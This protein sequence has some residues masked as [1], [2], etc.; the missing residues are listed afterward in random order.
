MNEKPVDNAIERRVVAGEVRA[1]KAESGPT[2]LAGYAAL[3][4]RETVIEGWYPFREVI[5]PGAFTET[6]KSDDVRGLFNHSPDHV[7]GRTANGTVRLAEDSL[8]LGYEIDLNADDPDAV[9]VGAK[10]ARGD[11]SQSSF[12]FQ[13]A[14]EEWDESEVKAGKL[15]LRKIKRVSPLFDVS[16]VTYP[17]YAETTVSAR[18]EA[19]AK[20]LS[21]SPDPPEPAKV[22]PVPFVPSKETAARGMVLHQRKLRCRGQHAA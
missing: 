6:I 15:P 5:L 8:G 11:V 10:V 16:A 4:N 2:V 1:K 19:R 14:E 13:V 3:F 20:A 22:A 17:A 9:S 12:A 21:A 18:A 7:L